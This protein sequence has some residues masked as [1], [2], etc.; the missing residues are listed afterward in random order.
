LVRASRPSPRTLALTPAERVYLRANWESLA[1]MRSALR[2]E[3]SVALAV[4]FGSRAR[5]DHRPNSDVDLLVALREPSKR[6]RVAERL[7]S[8]L[9]V[10]VQL[11]ALEHARQAPLLMDAVVRE[12]RVLVDRGG[13]WPVIAGRAEEI[14]REAAR[15]RRRIADE[16]DATFSSSRTDVS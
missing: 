13:I 5:G 15:E 16:F 14:G 10:P 11:A 2:T 12:G 9:G 8:A 4:L 7:E 3:P 6:R 1:G